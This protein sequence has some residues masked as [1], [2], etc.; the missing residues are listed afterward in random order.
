MAHQVSCRVVAP[1]VMCSSVFCFSDKRK[2][3][4]REINDHLFGRGLVDQS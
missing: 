3:S 4:M 2:D 1:L